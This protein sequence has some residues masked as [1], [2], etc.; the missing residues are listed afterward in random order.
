MLTE[1]PTSLLSGSPPS[2]T[3][4][5]FSAFLFPGFCQLSISARQWM[6]LPIFSPETG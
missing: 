6:V 4:V 5:P 2:A 3:T 1:T